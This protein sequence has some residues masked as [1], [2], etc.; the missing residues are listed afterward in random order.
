MMA[1]YAGLVGAYAYAIRESDS[2][3]LRSYVVASA[4]VGLFVALLL[5]L[6]VVTWV[7]NPTGLFGERALLGVVAILVL[8]PMAAPVLI[9]ARRHRHGTGHRRAD[10]A[11]G[12]AGYAFLASIYLGLLIS[13][14]SD[15]AVS[16]LLAPAVAALDT[17]PAV[18]GFLPPVIAV[19]LLLLAVRLTRSAPEAP[20]R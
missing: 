14:P 6:A 3:L 5:T 20:D 11:L 15:H 2:W 13:D 8:G 9:V 19:V 16:G 1:E 12:L 18:Y 17:L 10:L 7:A 4:L